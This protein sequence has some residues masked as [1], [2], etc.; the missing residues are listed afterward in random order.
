L[1]K[2]LTNFRT[3]YSAMFQPQLYAIRGWR[4]SGHIAMPDAP[5]PS[6][7]SIRVMAEQVVDA[8]VAQ[9]SK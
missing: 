7:F 9:A 8:L 1:G 4:G 2:K 5:Q 6:A 3:R